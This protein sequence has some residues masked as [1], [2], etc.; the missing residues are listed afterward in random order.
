[1]SYACSKC[2]LLLLAAICFV[3]HFMYKLQL[4]LQIVVQRLYVEHFRQIAQESR[5][6]IFE[7]FFKLLKMA[8]N[9]RAGL[10]G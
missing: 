3:I 6:N 8:E 9:M 2:L 10:T 1:M 7:Q 4:G 5:Q